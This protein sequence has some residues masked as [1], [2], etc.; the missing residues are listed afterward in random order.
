[1]PN[2]INIILALKFIVFDFVFNVLNDNR[3]KNK[4]EIK[5]FIHGVNINCEFAFFYL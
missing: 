1:M 4:N 3:I 5:E 2:Y